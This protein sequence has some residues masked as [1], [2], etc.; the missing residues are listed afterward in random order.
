MDIFRRKFGQ[1]YNLAF[2]FVSDDI[3]WV[4]DKIGT[5]KGT[6]AQIASFLD[7]QRLKKLDIYLV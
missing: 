5:K 4:K 3:N 7:K 1:N 2:I 6:V